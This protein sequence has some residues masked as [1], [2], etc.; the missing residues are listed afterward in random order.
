[1]VK[2]E[3]RE[4]IEDTAKLYG[5]DPDLV[6]AFVM[7]E[8]SGNP[9][10][11]RYEPAFYKRYI[12]PL[13]PKEGITP[14][15][16]IGRATS[17]GLMQIMGQV[18]RERGFKGEFEELLTPNQGLDWGCKHLKRFLKRYDPDLDAAIASYNAGSPRRTDTGRSFVN[19]RYVDKVKNY[20]TT[21]KRGEA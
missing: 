18:A 5:I 6:E 15:E 7:A 2:P 1:M 21:I 10:A 12:Q 16:A 8:S 9:Q 4:K 14:H 11:T 19:Q 17:W 3:I 13:I 20:Y